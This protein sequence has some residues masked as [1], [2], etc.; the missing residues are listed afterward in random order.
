MKYR[1]GGSTPP[2][3]PQPTAAERAADAKFRK[4]IKNLKPTPEQAAAIGRANRS[5]GYAKGGKVKKM[6]MGGMPAGASATTTARPTTTAAKPA[7]SSSGPITR[8]NLAA[9]KAANTAAKAAR[10]NITGTAAAASAPKLGPITRENLA[11]RKAANTAAKAAR[12]NTTGMAKGGK[13]TKFGKALV[14]KSAD[15]KGRAMMKKAGGGKCYASGGS[16]SSASKRADGCAVK[17]KTKGKMLARG[18]KT[19]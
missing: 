14:K 5:S 13:A 2:K 12:G 17:G 7:V 10:G 9:R 1:S 4:S 11:A 8:E 6:A 19:C 18:G 16:V 15:T 3:P